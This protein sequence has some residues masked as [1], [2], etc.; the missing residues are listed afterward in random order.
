MAIKLLD[1]FK[2]SNKQKKA[3]SAA[4]A[5]TL[6]AATLLS[7]TF[8]W[9]S[10]SQTAVNK[11]SGVAN[12]G[13][14]LHDY[15]NGENKDVFVE[16]FTNPDED[17]V[18][19]FVR[20]R[21]DEYM[22]IGEGAGTTD[23]NKNVT[24]VGKTEDN[25]PQID[26]PDT[27]ITH[28]P[29][30]HLPQ[31]GISPDTPMHEYWGWEM[32]GQ[33]NYMPTFNK[34]KDSLEADING[35]YEGPDG[36]D[37]VT[38][39]DTDDR[40]QDYKEYGNA[41]DEGGTLKEPVPDNGD[42]IYSV[43]GKETGAGGVEGTEDV[44]HYG[45]PTQNAKVI[46]MQDWINTDDKADLG[47]CWVYDSDGWAYWAEPLEPGETTGL[48]LDGI[49]LEKEPD[50][51][52]YYAINVVGQFATAGDWGDKDSQT[53]FYEDG[54]TEEGL[55]LLNTIAGRLP[56]V[57]YIA[58][59]NGK[60]LY[61]P[62]GTPY[63][64]E[65]DIEV[66][67]GTGKPSETYVLWSFAEED[68]EATAA[69]NG[70]IFS[71]T[72]DMV[73]KTYTLT[74]T[75]NYAP[76][77][78]ATTKVYVIPSDAVGVQ[79]GEQDGKLYVDYGDNTFRELTGDGL[80]PW[81]SAGEDKIIGNY[82][83]YTKVV[84]LDTPNPDY[85]SKF[86]GPDLNDLY[87]S[88]GDDG[89]LGTE[90]DVYVMSRSTW[91]NDLT[92]ILADNVKITAQGDATT[93]K[94]GKRLQLSAEVLLGDETAK[95]QSVTWSVSGNN[96]SDTTISNS[97]LLTIGADEPKNTELT[98]RA[99]STLMPDAQGTYQLTVKSLDY[100]DLGSVTSGGLTTVEI[101]G[102]DWYVLAKQ[103]GQA[104]IWST[105]GVITGEHGYDWET[106][107][108]RKS[109]NTTWLESTTVIK[110][111]AVL[112]E[113]TSRDE[114][115]R[116]WDTTEDKVFMLSE[117][118]LFNT[119]QNKPGVDG[120]DYTVGDGKL[121]LPPSMLRCSN[122]YWLLSTHESTIVN[123]GAVSTAGRYQSTRYSAAIHARLAVWVTLP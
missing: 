112:T 115:Y 19:I 108:L 87:R 18:P 40:Y 95:T 60:T 70:N 80:G 99:T 106:S 36:T 93:V 44:T 26:D 11:A 102:I 37:G 86:I 10:I 27:W 88:M 48:L 9:Q 83:D 105:E 82:G 69:L 24:I 32:G 15:F 120:K 109:L 117:A 1:K 45:K 7:G 101:D 54:I 23:P 17:G 76:D 30:E 107:S 104:L 42:L 113:I 111:K 31:G 81:V 56:E 13:G 121:N 3:A 122:P 33:T 43:T 59:N 22:E 68:T 92:H 29:M 47:P 97:G 79:E 100:S 58:I 96:S 39:G 65:A 114:N 49:K 89:L 28:H 61:V 94:V 51:D 57:T 2:L 41:Y 103:N 6:A 21:L 12:P 71:P 64:L 8:A 119:Y 34:D 14:R 72:E 5:V 46:T 66:K 25:D 50:E 52:W 123:M 98:V 20:V 90:D 73:G 53:G 4:T 55:T 35:T 16:N 75:S 74:A 38:P 84:V 67:N 85:G 91:P 118:D 62:A 116:N 77:K 63:E 78:T 110:E